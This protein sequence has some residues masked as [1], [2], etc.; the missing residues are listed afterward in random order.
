MAFIDTDTIGTQN[1]ITVDTPTYYKDFECRAGDC[2]DTCC[3]GKN[4]F[5]PDATYF[6]MLTVREDFGD[7]L[8]ESIKKSEGEAY[9]QFNDEQVCPF[10][11][12]C[13][14]CRIQEEMD[15]SLMPKEC[16]EKPR[17]IVRVG[18]YEQRDLSL[19]CP[20]S[21]R[22]L[23]NRDEEFDN[24]TEEISVEVDP[25]ERKLAFFETDYLDAIVDL[26]DRLIAVMGNDD[27]PFAKR[28][29]LL[30]TV[31]A[32]ANDGVLEDAD[33]SIPEIELE[34]ILNELADLKSGE[35]RFYYLIGDIRN[36]GNEKITDPAVLSDLEFY[37]G[38]LMCYYIYHYAVCAFF[39]GDISYE[40][41][42]IYKSIRFLYAAF[43]AC[44]AK[45]G[46]FSD[47]DAIRIASIYARHIETE[48]GN[49]NHLK[50]IY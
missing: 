37:M 6:K 11:S 28:L 19:L 48:K 29:S 18:E 40:I 13:G 24:D 49:E 34:V 17:S 3:K 20:E 39:D 32:S 25:E 30:K 27:I 38:R 15:A 5:V 12:S 21:G 16:I 46:S 43:A 26:R 35:K 44:Y 42:I 14:R 4:V 1:R 9:I 23:F 36:Y 10:L 33:L 41:N 45:N 22:L 7:E 2:E 50:C 31:L 47:A 8:R